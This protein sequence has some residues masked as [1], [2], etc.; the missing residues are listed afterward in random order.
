MS[1]RET[2]MPRPLPAFGRC[3]VPAPGVLR[4]SAPPAGGAPVEFREHLLRGLALPQKRTSPKYLYD[5]RGSRLFDEITRLPEYYPTRTELGILERRLPEIAETIGPRALVV[6]PGAGS[7]LKTRRLMEGLDR[8]VGIALID[9][10]P[11]YV[12]ASAERL[13]AALPGVEV[14]PVLADFTR[15]FAVP[16]PRARA[17]RTVVFFPGSTIG[18]FEAEEAAEILENFGDIAAS[19]GGDGGVLLG[20]DLVKPAGVLL[21]AYDDAAGVTARFNLNLLE[22]ANREA[23]ANF[24]LAAFRH[25]ARWNA[26]LSR[27]EMHLVSMRE[28]TVSVAGHAFRFAEGESIHTE[29]SRKFTRAT[30]EELTASAGLAVRAF[31][32]DEAGWFSL[33]WLEPA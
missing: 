17:E 21:R 30:L 18:N 24:D 13:R 10:S 9:I 6:E 7:G 11:E 2:A 8:P 16:A 23:G 5:E 31:W 19:R 26:G 27:I 3:R 29:S 15:P 25:E 33:S 12:R 22:R 32:T 4:R 14:L 28:Q 1:A 20:A